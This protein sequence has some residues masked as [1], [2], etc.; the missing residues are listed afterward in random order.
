M[1]TTAT[2]LR[3]NTVDSYT[4]NITTVRLLFVA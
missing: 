1:V 2:R 4:F 3:R